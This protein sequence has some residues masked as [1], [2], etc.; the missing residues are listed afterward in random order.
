MKSLTIKEAR[1]YCA[2]PGISVNLSSDDD[3]FYEHSELPRFVVKAPTE[4]RQIIDFIFT[5]VVTAKNYS[6]QGGLIWF[7][8]YD[9]GVL[10]SAYL[11]WKVIEDLRRANGDNRTLDLAP[12]QH[13]R[14]NEETE[15]KVFLL[16]AITFGWNGSFLPSGFDCLVKFDSSQR[17]FFQSSE[18][19]HLDKLFEALAPWSPEYESYE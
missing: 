2:Q 7:H 4:I 1:R 6:F 15:L 5:L 9:V 18:R 11:G 8:I 13:F 17:W 3:L 10:D 12:A 14:E 19:S 16:Q